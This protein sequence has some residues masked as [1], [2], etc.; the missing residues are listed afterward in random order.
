MITKASIPADGSG[1]TRLL[2]GELSVELRLLL[3]SLVLLLGR[4]LGLDHALQ[5]LL[6]L[7]PGLLLVLLLLVLLVFF[8]LLL[9]QVVGVVIV[10]IAVQRLHVAGLCGQSIWMCC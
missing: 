9:D 6:L 7:L 1:A 2:A 8:L 10:G 3:G 5:V 4:L